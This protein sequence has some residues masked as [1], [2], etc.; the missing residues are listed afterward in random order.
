M[1]TEDTTNHAI[2]MCAQFVNLEFD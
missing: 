1:F 2:E